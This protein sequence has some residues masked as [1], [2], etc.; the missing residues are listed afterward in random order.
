M[1]D[2]A[3]EPVTSEHLEGVPPAL[4]SS[5]TIVDDVP[6]PQPTSEKKP[7][8]QKAGTRDR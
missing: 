6:I 1:D 8:L 4:D 7:Q 3:D 2:E 5:E